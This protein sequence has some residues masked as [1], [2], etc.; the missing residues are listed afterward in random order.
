[1]QRDQ[2]ET[3]GT[4]LGLTSILIKGLWEVLEAIKMKM[5]QALLADCRRMF[6]ISKAEANWLCSRDQDK[7]YS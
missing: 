2:F 7:L 6:S 4:T 3:A 1:M 5:K